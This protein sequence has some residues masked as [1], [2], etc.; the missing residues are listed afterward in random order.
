AIA[1]GEIRPDQID[2]RLAQLPTDLLR[3]DVLFTLTPLTDEAIEEIV[4]TVFLPLV[5]LR[6]DHSI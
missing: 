3:H 2:G 6:A 1:R 5:Q 4:D